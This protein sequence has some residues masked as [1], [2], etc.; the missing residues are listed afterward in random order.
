MHDTISLFSPATSYVLCTQK[1]RLPE[2]D[3]KT[4]E[5]NVMHEYTFKSA[6]HM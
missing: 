1:A 5:N 6:T 2:G 4:S 3:E